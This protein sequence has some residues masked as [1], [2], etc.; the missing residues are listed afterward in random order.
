MLGY[1][2]LWEV[3]PDAKLGRCSSATT[4]F[5]ALGLLRAACQSRTPGV[6]LLA[7]P[8]YSTHSTFHPAWF[9]SR[10]CNATLNCCA[11]CIDD[12]LDNILLAASNQSTTLQCTSLCLSK[13]GC[14]GDQGKGIT[15][16]PALIAADYGNEAEVGA[17]LK[18]AIQSGRV[19][20]GDLFITTKVRA[21]SALTKHE[22]FVE[23]LS[24]K[25]LI[26]VAL[27]ALAQCG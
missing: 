12:A 20:R 9:S 15:H 10:C 3:P 18:G 4:A 1:K 23:T 17:A 2:S 8:C 11:E 25:S 16:T 14:E 24:I 21:L 19:T 5:A 26:K 7:G 6:L 27:Q 22:N 13:L